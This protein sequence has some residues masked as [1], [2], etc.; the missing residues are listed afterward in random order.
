MGNLLYF[1]PHHAWR[2]EGRSCSVDPRHTAWYAGDRP[3]VM[4]DNRPTP[5]IQHM[6][7][8]KEIDGCLA[9]RER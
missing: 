8:I 5:D 1:F 9:E 4:Y 6:I 2:G 7:M 3:K